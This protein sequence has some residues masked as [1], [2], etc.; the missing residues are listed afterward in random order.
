MTT[1]F[2]NT[3]WV[4]LVNRRFKEA[5][6]NAQSHFLKFQRF[7]ALWDGRLP[8]EFMAIFQ[9]PE[10]R[11][12]THYIPP[13]VFQLVRDFARK[14]LNTLFSV[15]PNFEL[16]HWP[17]EEEHPKAQGNRD[18]IIFQH[19]E[20]RG[21]HY[22]VMEDA[23]YQMA[24]YGHCVI[25]PEWWKDFE[26]LVPEE[27]DSNKFRTELSYE[28]PRFQVY[29]AYQ[30]LPSP[31]FGEKEQLA[32]CLLLEVIPFGDLLE[33]QKKSPDKY[34][35]VRDIKVQDINLSVVNK[36]TKLATV[37]KLDTTKPEDKDLY[38]VF[39][40]HY[41]D[42]ER[43]ITVANQ[44]YEIS[45]YADPD[46]SPGPGV[47]WSRLVKKEGTVFG[48]GIIEIIEDA[49]YEAFEK[50]WNRLNRQKR[51][52]VPGGVTTEDEA[53]SLLE[54]G[55]GRLTKVKG[56]IEN[57]KFFTE[58]QGLTL[59]EMELREESIILDEIKRTVGYEDIAVGYRPEEK[60]TATRDIVLK[61]EAGENTRYTLNRFEK[62]QKMIIRKE[63]CLNRQ[64]LL[65]PLPL[66][67]QRA[68]IDINRSDILTN[69]T[70]RPLGISEAISRP[71]MQK[72]FDMIV[73][74]LVS[75]PPDIRM[76]LDIDYYELIVSY[77]NAFR[78]YIRNAD[79]ILRDPE[80]V[81][82]PIEKE[83]VLLSQGYP[84]PVDPR[85]DHQK[86][87]FAKEGGHVA[88]MNELK[89]AGAPEEQLRPLMEHIAEHYANLMVQKEG[90]TGGKLAS[91]T[92]A[93]FNEESVGN[94]FKQI[95]PGNVE[96][97]KGVTG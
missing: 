45:N 31:H 75:L 87:L 17:K 38:P 9:Q 4:K 86:H 18:L 39:L 77:L 16:D 1:Q 41:L 37:E 51:L 64:F 85:E 54:A 26:P 46:R 49:L 68:G 47:I 80:K 93:G 66:D 55:A 62:I 58:H 90:V 22:G 92:S 84:V 25:L 21:D 33:K 73:E 7:D 96:Q 89:A 15:E 60:A 24:R 63:L 28:G 48:K 74:R 11:D 10:F 56:K 44:K 91:G 32:Y 81:M 5:D 70:I 59:N 19:E 14:V 61:E 83:N 42:G 95:L 6:E 78:P 20:E 52:N 36:W 76:N 79:K 27:D 72:V 13:K 82:I 50:R 57:Y 30:A 3:K 94:L 40:I 97:L 67:Y 53:P 88:F 8:N 23:A 43:R 35:G 69:W 12:L 71:I 29:P 34:H 2:E 65:S